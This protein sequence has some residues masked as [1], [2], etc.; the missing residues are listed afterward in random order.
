MLLDAAALRTALSAASA[1]CAHCAALRAPGWESVTG[2]IG[3]PLLEPV[4]S[5]RDLSIEEPTLDERH[6]PGT[7]YWHARAPIVPTHF[8]YNRCTV[9]RCPQCRRGFLQYTEAGGYYVDHR[10]RELDPTL[11]EG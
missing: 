5:L 4:G 9:W 3:A 6:A 7:S 11:L 1:G 8:P 2:P 10:L